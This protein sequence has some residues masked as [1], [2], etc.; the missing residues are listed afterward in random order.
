MSNKS[1]DVGSSILC[2]GVALC[3][4][5]FSAL[6]TFAQSPAK[7]C[8]D[9]SAPCN[10]PN[11]EFAPYELSFQLPRRLKPNVG[12]KSAPFCAIVLKS[13]PADPDADCDE[14]EYSSKLEKE[15]KSVQSM[16]ADRKVFADQQC[17]DMGAVNY[18]MGGKS[19]LD[20]FLAIYG[21][22]TRAE[23]EAIVPK[24]KGK[25]PRAT[26]RLIQAVFEKIDQ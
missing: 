12:Y 26:V 23:A 14:G 21:G 7:V 15:R 13:K 25:Y 18:T 16:F 20:T 4:L 22:A 8:S 5:A 11:K 10:S 6:T 2:S 19:S 24:I 17:P 9:P 1:F 3:I